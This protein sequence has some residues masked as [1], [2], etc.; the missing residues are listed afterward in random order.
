MVAAQSGAAGRARALAVLATLR[1]REEQLQALAGA[2]AGAPPLGYRLPFA[3]TTPTSA[4]RLARALLPDLLLSVGSAYGA[5]AGD[6]PGL[7]GLVRWSAQ[8]QAQAGAWG[9]GTD[10]VPRARHAVSTRPAT[11][12]VVVPESFAALLRGRPAEGFQTGDAWLDRL[13]GL[14]RD[15]AAALGADPRTG[16]PGTAS[17]R[18][19]C[20]CAASSGEAGRPQGR[21]AA[22]RGAARAPGPAAVGRP[23]R[24]APAARPTRRRWTLLLERLDADRDLRDVRVDDACATIGDLL[25]RLRPPGHAAADPAQRRGAAPAGPRWRRHRPPSRAGSSSRPSPSAATWSVTD[26][27]D[28]RLVHTDLHYENVLAAG[29]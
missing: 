28:A 8:L 2:D 4:A 9:R 7:V 22:P 13:P 6:R 14:V 29:P 25:G 24:G 12:A 23:R 15:V 27:V 18:S 20:R 5:G 10:A 3:V 26:G 17:A 16:R 19:C 1:P 11:G 21:L